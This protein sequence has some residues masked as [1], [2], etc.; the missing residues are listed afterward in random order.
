M[1]NNYQYISKHDE[2]VKSAYATLLSILKD[3]QRGLRK[4]FT[5]QFKVVGSY[6]RNMI[7]YRPKSNVGFDL[8]VNIYPNDEENN[9]T[10]KQLK[11]KLMNEFSKHK[12]KY[13]YDRV[14]DSTRAITLKVID[15]NNSKLVHHVDIAIVNDYVDDEGYDCQEYVRFNKKHNSYTWEP[16]DEG[17]YIADKID[18]IHDEDLWTEL[19]EMYLYLKNKNSNEDK[20]SRSLFA[21]AVNNIC[22]EYGY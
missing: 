16:Q 4:E 18:W 8:D 3:V 7:T 13:G 6:E 1:S 19:R 12:K 21:E 15:R 2:K 10:A 14:E 11:T 17:F 22:N 20:H 9:Y 5:F